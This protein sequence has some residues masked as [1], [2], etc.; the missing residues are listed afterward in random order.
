MK[1]AIKV[2]RIRKSIGDVLKKKG[3][4]PESMHLTVNRVFAFHRVEGLSQ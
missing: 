1:T 3:Q 4:Y 2:G